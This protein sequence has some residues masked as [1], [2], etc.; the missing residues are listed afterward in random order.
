MIAALIA[1][2]F[3]LAG[4]I[5]QRREGFPTDKAVTWVNAYLFNLVLPALALLYI[6]QI[7]PGWDL[8]IPI[9]AAW[10]TFF[11]SWLLFGILGKIL[12]WTPQVTGCL[13]IVAGL[14]NTSFLGFPVI[15]ALY[16][17]AGLPVALLMDQGGSFLLV[18]SMA[19]IIASL[20]SHQ[21]GNLGSIPLKIIKFPP[22]GFLIGTLVMSLMG[23]STPEFLIPILTW[24]GKTM[25]PVALLAIGLRF[26]IQKADFRSSH[27]WLG[28][29]YRL[30]FAPLI[31]F[32]IYRNFLDPDGLT[33]KVTV[34]ESAMAP[35]I[36]GSIVA[37]NYNLAP[38]LAALLS[39][40]GMLVS[41]L[42][43]GIWFWFLG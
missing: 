34:M 31:V 30:V 7:E 32:L 39:G 3:L 6:P 27:F 26:R 4:L 24:I 41:I 1:F 18:S 11:L 36:T 9:S 17:K 16:G 12:N 8:L 14:A 43:L 19:I 25:A 28:L 33:F 40:L 42:S 37:I 38:R 10:L 22:F 29:S 2:L 20:Y 35:M 21:K 15:E 13:A 23:W 5:L